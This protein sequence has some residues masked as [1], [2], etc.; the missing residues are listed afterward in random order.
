M[1]HILAVLLISFA[2][3]SSAR[4]DYAEWKKEFNESKDSSECRSVKKSHQWTCAGFYPNHN[5][6]FYDMGRLYKECEERV[7][8]EAE[9]AAAEKEAAAEKAAAEKEAAAKKAQE[10]KAARDKAE[11]ISSRI[12][13][14][15]SIVLACNKTGETE[16][17]YY[18]SAYEIKIWETQNVCGIGDSVQYCQVSKTQVVIDKDSRTDFILSR[19]TGQLGV[20]TWGWNGSRDVTKTATYTC[21]KLSTSNLKF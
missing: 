11:D 9:D 3:I 19:V 6:C 12:R 4:A 16:G 8:E 1:K 17:N 15:Q 14:K 18:P 20:R 13:G 5:S 7:K 10:E 2:F 21:V